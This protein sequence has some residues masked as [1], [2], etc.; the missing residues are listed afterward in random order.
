M[1]ETH[2]PFALERQL[3]KWPWVDD[4]GEMFFGINDLFRFGDEPSRRHWI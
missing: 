3:V 4:L 2:L 1:E